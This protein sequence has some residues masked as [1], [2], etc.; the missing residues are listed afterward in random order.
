MVDVAPILIAYDGSEMAKVG[1]RHAGSL[2][3]PDRKAIVLTV[4]DYPAVTSF[5][6]MAADEGFTR[7]LARDAERVAA[8]G[9][10]LAE[11]SGFD[12]TPETSQGD[13]TWDRIVFRAEQ[14]SADLIVMGS[15][16]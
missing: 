7:S 10:R 11:Q 3:R 16:G 5:A 12:A 9:A 13:P 6:P 14:L 4:W 15:H 2:L 8:E 1:I